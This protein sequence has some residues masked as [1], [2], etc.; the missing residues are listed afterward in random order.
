MR[1][2]KGC[3]LLPNIPAR[4]RT[5]AWGGARGPG[6]PLDFAARRVLPVHLPRVTMWRFSDTPRRG[7]AQAAVRAGIP[8][9][10]GRS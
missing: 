3:S 8:M 5:Y 9:V 2:I 1:R 7:R 6:A 4:G 10:E